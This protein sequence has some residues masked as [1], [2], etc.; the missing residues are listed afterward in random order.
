MMAPQYPQQALTM[1]PTCNG[2]RRIENLA[3][4]VPTDE[5][6]G[7]IIEYVRREGMDT[8]ESIVREKLTPQA[9]TL[10]RLRVKNWGVG[11]SDPVDV[12][13]TARLTMMLNCGD[14]IVHLG[15]SPSTIE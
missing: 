12:L 13:A 4:A 10:A 7:Q 6:E 9:M 1:L 15:N 3:Q 14:D 5:V 8:L 2:P 11:I